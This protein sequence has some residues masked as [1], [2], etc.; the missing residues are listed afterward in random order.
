MCTY[1]FVRDDESDATVEYRVT[2]AG[3]APTYDIYG[4]SPGEGPEIEIKRVY[5]LDSALVTLSNAE[6]ERAEDEIIATLSVPV[7]RRRR[8]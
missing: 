8:G 5:G 6:Y 7:R 4:G 3:C 2:Y 1:D